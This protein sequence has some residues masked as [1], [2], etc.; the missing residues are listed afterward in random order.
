MSTHSIQSLRDTFA[1][2]A[3]FAVA[4]PIL[5]LVMFL[6]ADMPGSSSGQS[7]GVTDWYKIGATVV[8][9][10]GF[11]GLMVDTMRLLAGRYWPR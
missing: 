6:V 10:A 7:I 5:L 8:A 3:A 9:F 4:T 2:T 1:V 11:A